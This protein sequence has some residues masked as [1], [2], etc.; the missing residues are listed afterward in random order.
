MAA[1]AVIVPLGFACRLA[2][3]FMEGRTTCVLDGAGLTEGRL[4]YAAPR[5]QARNSRSRLSSP[6]GFAIIPR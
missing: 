3:G 5:S 2:G 4:R 1:V 6:A